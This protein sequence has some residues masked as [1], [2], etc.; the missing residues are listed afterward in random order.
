MKPA[1]F[2]YVK[3]RTL[4][5]AVGILAG[6]DGDAKVLAGGQSL[7]PMLNMRL[8][9]PPLV[10][11]VNGLPGLD[12]IRPTPDGGLIAGALVRHADLVSS[13]LVWAR[14]PLLA[15]AARHIGYPAIRNRGTL[16]GSLAHA[17]PAAELPAAVM[18]LEADLTL[19]SAMG[20]RT[21]PAAA[22]FRGVLTTALR[23]DELLT[24]V[25]I[26]AAGAAWGFGELARRPGDYA[27]AGVAAVLRPA[28]GDRRRCAAARLV[29]FGVGH[30]PVRLQPAEASVTGALIDAG[31]SR[32]AGLA[33]RH[34]CEPPEDVHA[35]A[36]YRRHLAAV[37]TEQ[38]LL[39][40]MTRLLGAC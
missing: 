24:E 5:E 13:P 28:P 33:A 36:E 40:A 30:V 10:V 20:T 25:R 22:F 12:A 3:P 2:R 29:A 7:V 38:V 37:L 11:D 17:D 9:R 34:A 39:E 32:R 14:A 21:L 4:E 18:A 6:A 23:P 8:A 15:E 35:S 16:G 26:P 27:L 1:P 31:T 19:V